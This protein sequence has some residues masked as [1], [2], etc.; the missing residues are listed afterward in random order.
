MEAKGKVDPMLRLPKSLVDLTCE[1]SMRNIDAEVEVTDSPAEPASRTLVLGHEDGTKL[2]ETSQGPGVHKCGLTFPQM[3]DEQCE[4]HVAEREDSASMGMVAHECQRGEL[5]GVG[6]RCTGNRSSPKQTLEAA[7]EF[8][9]DRDIELE[10]AD[11]NESSKRLKNSEAG[12]GRHRE[13]EHFFIGVEE[14]IP[15]HYRVRGKSEPG[16]LL[17]RKR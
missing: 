16:R 14:T 15:T 12:A 4:L 9:M 2:C 6:G 11:Q 3:S 8:R 10:T 7:D 5:A 17:K 13:C 1:N